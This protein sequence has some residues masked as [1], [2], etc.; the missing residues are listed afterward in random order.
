MPNR[1]FEDWNTWPTRYSLRPKLCRP[2][3]IS[4]RMLSGRIERNRSRYEPNLRNLVEK[5]AYG[6]NSSEWVL[7]ITRVS[8]C[9]T[10]IG[11]EPT[12]ALV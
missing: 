11:G 10:D 5:P 4:G 1:C 8:R 3:S 6:P 2:A 9:G 7:P 12:A